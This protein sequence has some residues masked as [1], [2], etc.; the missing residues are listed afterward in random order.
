MSNPLLHAD[1]LQ[2]FA[3]IRPDHIGPAVGEL[4]AQARAAVERAAD[5]ATPATWEHLVDALD[6]ATEP[7]W[8]AWSAAGHLNAVV[9]TPELR[10][11]YNEALPQVVEFSTWVGLHE[12]LY[13]QYRRLRDSA[14]F[15]D[16]PP[17]RQRIV[18]LGLRDFR[19][20]GVE[21]PPADRK[22]FASLHERHAEVSQKFS[23][24]VLDATD[25]WALYAEDEGRLAGIPAD[26]L[27][28]ARAA[29]ESDG[30]PGWKLTLQA[31]CYIPVMQYA[32]S[33][34]L[35]AEI[36][37]AYG[38]RA[39]DTGD[40]RFDNSALIEELL[41][42]RREEA[43]L[44]GFDTYANRQLQ[45]RMARSPEQVLGFLRDLAG[46]ARR[47]AER[48]LQEVRAFA[49]DTLG[50]AELQPWD[51]AY[52]SERLRQA[53]FA[54]SEEELKPYFPLPRVL[55]GLFEILEQLFGV[56]TRSVEAPVWHPDVQVVR[57]EDGDGHLIGHYYLDLYA[58]Q[59]KQPGAWVDLDRHRRRTRHGLQT[60]VVFLTCN[61]APPAADRPSLLTH[62]DIITLFHETG[63][64]LHALLSEVDDIGASPFSSVE[65]DAIELPSQ[66]M[67]NFGWEWDV[68]QRLSAHIETGKPLER[69]LFDK[70]QA[71]RNFQSGLGAV[72][73][74]EFALFDM[75]L[76]Q[77]TNE[78]DAA[79]VLA[80]LDEVRRE[81]AVVV[82]PAWHRSPHSFSHIFAGGYSAGY[83][84]YKW[85][86]VLS[87]DAYAAFEEAAG[88]H[89]SR[90][91]PELGRRFR[92]TV[93]AVGGSQPAEEVFR[94]FRGRDPEIDA[95]LRHSGMAEAH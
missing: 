47:Y 12:G 69:E 70:L 94:T 3:A 2:D 30:K 39:S 50:L 7:L 17:V 74:I 20:S 54:Y 58:R 56:R 8:R 26:V 57:V 35:R 24:N 84:S 38:T 89:G 25:A 66:F 90:L 34:E 6:D 95:L 76:H 87:A 43:A 61:F 11:A 81:V 91:N 64:A 59:G 9:N 4:L 72:R 28:A 52:A 62:D 68:L 75:L 77:R 73:Q 33:T 21:L 14:H 63:H 86:E 83:Y 1:G 23:E 46:R 71:A 78:T 53:R 10:E 42:L 45:T 32:E 55:D 49:R 85:A 48:D 88:E 51:L 19:L 27:A 22:R 41:Q 80:I 37:R 29:A 44:L 40:T 67:E 31:P 82:P 13:R 93:L 36:Y 79:E 16:L 65:W 5:P 60:P 15:N 18:E 92:Q